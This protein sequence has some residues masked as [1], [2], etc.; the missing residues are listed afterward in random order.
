VRVAPAASTATVGEESCGAPLGGFV[1]R[2]LGPRLAGA[3]QVVRA[4]R[5]EAEA[6]VWLGPSHDGWAPEYAVAHDRRLDRDGAVDDLG[7]EDRM[8]PTGTGLGRYQP[9][10]VRFHLEPAVTAEIESERTVRLSRTGMGDW[11]L[12]N[13]APEVLIEPS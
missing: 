1:G 2:V 9:F 3:P 7:G 11:L 5:Q 6:A 12:H 8:P 4:A 10:A 13:D